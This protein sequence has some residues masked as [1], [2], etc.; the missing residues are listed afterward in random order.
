MNIYLGWGS[1]P[2]FLMLLTPLIS[3]SRTHNSPD[4]VISVTDFLLKNNG[5]VMCNNIL[6]NTQCNILTLLQS[7]LKIQLE[8]P[9]ECSC[10]TVYINIQEPYWWWLHVPSLIFICK[11]PYNWCRAFIFLVLHGPS[12]ALPIFRLLHVV[13]HPVVACA[14]SEDLY[15]FSLC[16]PHYRHLSSQSL[17]F[18]FL[19]CFYIWSVIWLKYSIMSNAYWIQAMSL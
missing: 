6:I 14:E 15:F 11:A 1:I 3:T 7:V 5:N 8:Y 4:L 13:G 9:E 19:N 16:R 10:W 17:G 2:D 12:S 18:L